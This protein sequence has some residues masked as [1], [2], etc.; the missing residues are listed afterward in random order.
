MQRGRGVRYGRRF[1]IEGQV[2]AAIKVADH[3]HKGYNSVREKVKDRKGKQ[4]VKDG[5]ALGF[6]SDE[7]QSVGAVSTA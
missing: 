4:R 6:F 3:F 7:T 2:D 1:D 5:P